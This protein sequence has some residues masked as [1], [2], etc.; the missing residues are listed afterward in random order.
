MCW[1]RWLL[2]LFLLLTFM[3]LMTLLIR[4]AIWLLIMAEGLYTSK[5]L[6]CWQIFSFVFILVFYCCWNKL[7]QTQWFKKNTNLLCSC[8][9]VRKFNTDLIGLRS[10]PSQGL[11]FSLEPV[12]ER[13]FLCLS[14]LDSIFFLW[15]PSSNFIAKES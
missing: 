14:I 13:L 10:R 12:G 4:A 3:I 5:K 11:Y 7:L 6:K 8:C 15:S 9:V 1:I 2:K